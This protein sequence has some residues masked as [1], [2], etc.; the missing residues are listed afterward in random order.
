MRRRI[1]SQPR[2]RRLFAAQTVSRWGDTFNAV[3]VVILVF[4]ITGSGLRVAATVAFEVV[5][6]LLLAPFA[7]VVAD[8]FDRRRVMIAADL[9][10]A[11]LLFVL[12]GGPHDPA[13]IYVTAA[14][15]A[16]GSVFFNPAAS[17]LLPSTVDAEDLVD[18]NATLWSAAVVSQIALAPLA[19]VLIAVVGTRPAFAVN[20]ASFVGSAVL[21]RG[22]PAALAA[23]PV[24]HRRPRDMREGF[25]MVRTY[26]LVRVLVVVQ[27]LASL[28]AGA[29]SAL[30]VVL[31]QRRLG[32]GPSGFGLLLAA[33]GVGAATGPWLV[34]RWL[35]PPR[36]RFAFGA[37]GVRGGVDLLLA[38]VRQPLIAGGALS[39]YG[40][41]TSTGT[42]VFQSV[43]QSR[44]P[45]R[46][47]GRA[48]A[49]F[50]LVWNLGRLIS[51]AAGGVLADAIRVT[52]VYAAGG[53]MLLAASS[54]GFLWSHRLK[55]D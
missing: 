32:V 33:I 50:D 18:A 47:R 44:L 2:F 8:R 15:L 43:L 38:S 9:F 34:R 53:V 17:A 31:A 21:L 24:A 6:M 12:I 20:A 51:L 28:S 27:F 10:R 39:V 41:G 3:A 40:L 19:G 4:E 29:T 5:P 26:P 52:A 13:L 49:M 11:A 23:E 1:L 22:L 55:L 48:F 46:V 35:R 45:D 30:L 42:V 36:L 25:A 37:Y 54:I 7:G 16:A 14:G